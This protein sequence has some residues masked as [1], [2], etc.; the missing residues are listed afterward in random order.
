MTLILQPICLGC[1][2]FQGYESFTVEE[3]EANPSLITKNLTGY[4]DAFP[5][6]GPVGAIPANI[7][8]SATDHRMMVQGDGGIRFDPE[9]DADADYAGRLFR[10]HV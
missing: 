8:Q 10:K 1:K 7:W 9:T 4:C 5:K 6:D 3:A 2:H